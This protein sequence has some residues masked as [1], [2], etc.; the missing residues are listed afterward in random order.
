MFQNTDYAL[1]VLK[2]NNKDTVLEEV[3]KKMKGTNFEELIKSMSVTPAFVTIPCFQSN[4]ITHLK[5]V[6]QEVPTYKII[7]KILLLNVEWNQNLKLFFSNWNM[8]T[9]IKDILI[10]C[11]DFSFIS[12]KHKW[13]S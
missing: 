11:N 9:E 6:L 12:K 2:P 3:L 5:S 1:L 10:G 7:I 13:A 4:N 8:W